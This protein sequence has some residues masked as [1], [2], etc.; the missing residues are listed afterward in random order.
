MSQQTFNIP[1]GNA[2]QFHVALTLNSEPFP[3]ELSQN[4]Q[5]NLVSPSGMRKRMTL[6]IST[7]E[8]IVSVPPLALLGIHGIELKGTLNS[9]NWRLYTGGIINYT[10]QSEQSGPRSI[11]INADTDNISCVVTLYAPMLVPPDTT[12]FSEALWTELALYAESA[13]H[14]IDARYLKN[15]VEADILTRTS[16]GQTYATLQQAQDILSQ[17]QA[18]AQAVQQIQSQLLSAAFWQDNQANDPLQEDSSQEDPSD[19][20]QS[21]NDQPDDQP[22]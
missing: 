13:G 11:E 22:D 4:V 2:A 20:Q 3:V 10:S 7:A 5:C 21:D 16:A 1:M 6:S 9:Q 12:I 15:L 19:T 14:A 17:A 18:T 8:V